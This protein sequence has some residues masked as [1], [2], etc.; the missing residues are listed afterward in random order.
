MNEESFRFKQF[1]VHQDKC[2]KKGGTDAVLLGSWLNPAR[3]NRILDIGTGSGIIALMLAQKTQAEIDAIDIDECAYLQAKENFRISPWFE[4][5]HIIH[6]SF[7][8][9]SEKSP[10]RY[11][12]IV[13]NPPYFHHAS[14]PNGESR[15]NARHNDLLSFKEIVEGV[16]R[17]LVPSGIF[18]LILPSREGIEFMEL[19]QKRGLFCNRIVKIK[20]KPDRPEKRVIMVFSYDLSV[21][22]EESLITNDMNGNYTDEYI[23]LTREYYI[24]LKQ[25]PDQDSSKQMPFSSSSLST[26]K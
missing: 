2:A 14:K 3:A 7:Q 11:D 18:C 8:E 15:L 25:N 24:G 23:E 26:G 21:I 12:L 6:Q 13:S 17:L 10:E 19:A 16:K 1:T 4:R 9:Y 22:R 20:T 5:L